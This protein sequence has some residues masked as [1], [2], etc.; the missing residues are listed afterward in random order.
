MLFPIFNSISYTLA[1]RPGPL[2]ELVARFA[3]TIRCRGRYTAV[4]I[5][6][7]G[8]TTNFS[9]LRVRFLLGHFSAQGRLA[10]PHWGRYER[11]LVDLNAYPAYPHCSPPHSLGG[12]L[13]LRMNGIST[14][15]HV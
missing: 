14:V 11:S 5:E 6:F 7:T 3:L 15:V 2:V 1:Y 12:V 9:H 13:V 10:W 8:R 4:I